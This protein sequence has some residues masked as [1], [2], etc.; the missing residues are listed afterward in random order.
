MYLDAFPGSY[1]IV[2][3]LLGHK[4]IQTTIDTY[5][6]TEFTAAFRQYDAYI[7]KL[8]GSL[9]VPTQEARFVKARR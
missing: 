2:R 3:M 9:G 7:Q 5:C 1:G 4:L 6:G 8:H